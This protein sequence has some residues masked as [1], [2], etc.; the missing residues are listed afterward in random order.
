MKR[1]FATLVIGVSF[2]QARPQLPNTFP[3]SGNVGI[4]TTTPAV[5]VDFFSS[6]NE[7]PTRLRIANTTSTGTNAAG[8]YPTIE[9]LGARGDG[10]TTFGGRLALGTRRTSGT[11]LNN[12]TL[13]LVLFG[14]QYGTDQT[15]QSSKILYPASIQGIAEGSFS[16]STTMPTAIAFLTGSTGNDVGAT[17]LSYGTE[18]MRITSTGNVGIGTSNPGTFKLAVEGKIGAREVKVTLA[19]WADYVF[20][21]RYNLL[22]L[23]DLE[24][25]LNLNGHLPNIPS[26][27]EVED[28]KGI[29][30]GE[31]T[32]KLLE[33]VEE[34]T[35]YVIELNNAN[36]AL[37]EEN[38]KIKEEIKKLSGKK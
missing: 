36:N 28:N 6:D 8:S 31:M 12:Q 32:A 18:R 30:L 26:A 33:K 21:P 27:K 29:E 16:G 5:R 22:P 37:K 19:S 3:S 20:Y 11:A 34:L 13:G 10:N 23:G 24:K 9:L 7:G 4:G 15:F 2:Y 25:Y 35:L 1:L 38:E 17:N 14:G